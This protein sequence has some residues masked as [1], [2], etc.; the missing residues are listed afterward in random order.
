MNLCSWYFVNFSLD[1]LLV[2]AADVH[3]Y[4]SDFRVIFFILFFL[5]LEL[6]PN[7]C[8]NRKH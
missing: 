5:N 1:L 6:S 7:N 2:P 4:S 3:V 8:N